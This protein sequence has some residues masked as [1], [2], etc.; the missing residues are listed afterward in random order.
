MI[1]GNNSTESD[2]EH[3]QISQ[4]NKLIFETTLIPSYVYILLLMVIGVPGNAL[5][6]Y[7][8]Q[9]KIRN[10]QLSSNIFIL[11]LSWFDLVNCVVSLPIEIKFLSSLIMFDQPILCKLSRFLTFFCNNAS[12]IILLTIAIDRLI[13]FL[14]GPVRRRLKPNTAKIIV[15]IAIF[16]SAAVSWPMIIFFGTF[17]F[18]LGNGEMGK[19]CLIVNKYAKSKQTI[20]FTISLLSLHV[21]FDLTFFII[22]SIIGKKIC[23]DSGLIALHS[24]ANG[25][26]GCSPVMKIRKQSD[27]SNADAN[28]TQDTSRS[29]STSP[30]RVE[31]NC[32]SKECGSS[33]GLQTNRNSL[34]ITKLMTESNGNNLKHTRSKARV[35]PCSKRVSPSSSECKIFNRRTTV[36]RTSFILFI[37]TMAYV[38]SFMPYCV[39][40][41]V[42]HASKTSFYEEL[43]N[44]EKAVYQIFLRSY[45]LSSA[46]NP[47]IYSLINISFRKKCKQTFYEFVYFFRKKPEMT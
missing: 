45:S 6:C 5:V 3:I 35:K 17:T 46:I 23:Y 29:R 8:Y 34:E 16:I 30:Y 10:R 19:S 24:I 4:L 32:I 20:V 36:N 22:Y 38:I 15:V 13:A 25:R 47:I 37:V 2:L 33:V 40:V 12:S 28:L 21:V 9:I 39:I 26:G 31:L 41:V 1:S 43:S 42:R 11:A 27:S 14:S 7:I 18:P 44:A